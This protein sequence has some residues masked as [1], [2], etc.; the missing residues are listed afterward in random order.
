MQDL[1]LSFPR[2]TRTKVRALNNFLTMENILTIR[3]AT[4]QDPLETVTL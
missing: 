3:Q 1:E 2:V 4:D